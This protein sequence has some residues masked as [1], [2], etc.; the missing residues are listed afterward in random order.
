MFLEQEPVGK[1]LTDNSTE[2]HW[3]LSKNARQM[4]AQE[5]CGPSGNGIIE[6]YHCT[7]MAIMER[8]EISII[9]VVFWYN[10]SL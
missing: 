5:T 3:V 4:E 8:E 6:Q 1:V 9:K 7:I 2:F 10:M